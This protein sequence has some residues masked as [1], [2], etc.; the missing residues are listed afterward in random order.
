MA[1]TFIKGVSKNGIHKDYFV[2]TEATSSLRGKINVTGSV[3]QNTLMMRSMVCRI[4]NF[5]RTPY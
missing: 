3:E 4:M 1:A 5:S 2:Q